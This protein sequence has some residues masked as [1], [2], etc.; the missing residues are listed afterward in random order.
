MKRVACAPAI[1]PP[2][3]P[4]RGAAL[5]SWRGLIVASLLALAGC[6][7]SGTAPDSPAPVPE[8]TWRQVDSDILAA[9]RSA[10]EPAQRSAHAAMNGWMDLVYR[11]TDSDFIPW[12]SSYWTRQWLTMKVAWYKLSAEG[13]TDPTVAR[14]AIYLQEQYRDRVLEPVA[15]Q[16]GPDTIMAQ[17]TKLYVSLLGERLQDIPRRHG[18]PPAL[19]DQRLKGIP[20]IALGPSP[21][22]GASLYQVVHAAPLDRLPAY[23]ALIDRIGRA[24]GGAGD[25]ASN[26]GIASVVQKTSEQLV[27]ELASSSAASVVGSGLGRVAGT[28]LSLGVA[29]VSALLRENERPEMEAQLRR[30][31]NAAFDEEWLELMRNPDSGVMAGVWHISGQIEG[32]LGATGLPVDSRW[33]G[34]GD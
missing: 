12:F 4:W 22:Q 3:R 17:T 32:S 28:V 29:G 1:P 8:S 23:V 24:P 21:R 15:E 16:T 18:V 27:G 31:L 11:R 25:W 6:A 13:E 34:S 19:F 20:A 26:A 33:P 7:T 10:S 5:A 2:A 9:S 14:L 30:N